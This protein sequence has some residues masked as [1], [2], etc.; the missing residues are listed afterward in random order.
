MLMHRGA[1]VLVVTVLGMVL[2]ARL[3]VW[4][5][6]RAA[7][8]AALQS[9]I[10]G[11]G[12]LPALVN[13]ALPRTAEEAVP[14]HHRP[15]RLQGEW[16]AASTVFLENR[17]M[18][19]Q[20]GFFVVTPFRLAGAEVGAGNVVLVQRGWTPRDLMDRLRVPTVPTAGAPVEIT[21]HLVPPPSK[22]Y[23]FA[24]GATGPIRQNLDVAEFARE[25]GLAL[26]PFSV[27]QSDSSASAGDGLLR[28]W[29]APAVDIHKHLGYAFQWFALCA[30][31]AGLYVWFQLLRPRLQRRA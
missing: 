23:D 26:R 8:K 16:I 9:A 22:L 25:T 15:V 5:L 11:R 1:L 31:I 20:P 10:D 28:Q 30:L 27:L 21:G 12:R 3:G 24:G 29:P 4:Q 13:L 18:H 14:Q 2:T 6:D 7:Q 19:G 17:Q